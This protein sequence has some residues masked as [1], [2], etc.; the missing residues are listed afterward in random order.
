MD[1][2]LY[3]GQWTIIT[4]ES[5]TFYSELKLDSLHPFYAISFFSTDLIYI[6]WWVLARIHITQ[7]FEM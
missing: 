7:Y 1:I 6:R 4:Y 5:S 3:K 2:P